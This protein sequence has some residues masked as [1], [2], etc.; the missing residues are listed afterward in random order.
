[1]IRLLLLLAAVFTLNACEQHKAENLPEKLR[2]GD[3]HGALPAGASSCCVGSV[4]GALL[5]V[6]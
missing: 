5:T 6:R 3:K 4:A 1:M 2:D